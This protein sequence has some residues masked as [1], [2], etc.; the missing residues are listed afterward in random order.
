MAFV[1]PTVTGTQTLDEYKAQLEKIT[2]FAKR[3]QIDLADGEFS[4]PKTLDPSEIYWPDN[5]QADIHIMYKNPEA[6]VNELLSK[7]PHL[8]IVHAEAGGNLQALAE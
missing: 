7:N 1:C 8:L 6:A 2:P 4:S 3:I 5:I